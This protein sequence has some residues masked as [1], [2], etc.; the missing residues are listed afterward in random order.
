MAINPK[1]LDTDPKYFADNY[2][3][4][5][6]RFK[7]LDRC[8]LGGL[9]DF[10][11]PTEAML[12]GSYVD[13][14]ISG[15]LDQFIKD[16]PQIIS[17]RG[18]TKGQLK[19]GFK[20]AEEICEYIENTPTI[21]QFMQGD[22]QT[23]MTGEISGVPVKGKFDIYSK[24]IAINDLKIVQ[25]IRDGSGYVNFISHWGYDLQLAVY[26]ELCY[27]NTGERLPMFIIAITKES[28]ID[29]AI[30]HVPDEILEGKLEEFESK[31][32]LYYDIWQGKES[33]NGCGVCPT[34]I[35]T[36]VDTEIISYYELI[37]GN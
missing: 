27:Q 5:V 4:S 8:Q 16:N 19:V 33:A 24:G 17:S 34:C 25:K 11:E 32:K 1:E 30:I 20:K 36:R 28:P 2:Y 37:G 10:G 23:V 3:M 31:V 6:S 12:V 9:T 14:Y 18:K 21:K 7:R 13:N 15:T 26:Q 29:S 35:G 22:K